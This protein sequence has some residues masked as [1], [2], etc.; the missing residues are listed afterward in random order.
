M[1]RR[2][3]LRR[4][5]LT[6]LLLGLVAFVIPPGSGPSAAPDAW[7]YAD[8][9]P[10]VNPQ[11]WLCGGGDPGA[12]VIK[13]EHGNWHCTW[14]S[15]S[16]P[17]WGLSFVGF[18]RQFILDY[19]L[20]RLG[21][22]GDRVEIWDF[23]PNAV[24][25][26]DDETTATAFT[27]CPEYPPDSRPAGALCSGCMAL[28]ASLNVMNIG[29][30]ATLGHAG[31]V[32]NSSGWHG[33]FH[34]AAG[35]AGAPC[36]E[37]AATPTAT[38]D[39]IFWMGHLKVDDLARTWQRA[40]AADIVVV[41]DRSGSMNDDCDA[42]ADCSGP[43]PPSD[44]GC[45]LNAAKT[46]ALL[47]A[48]LLDDAGVDGDQ[49][50]IG[51]VSFAGTASQ[52]VGLTAATG[53]VTDN[54][55]DETPFEAAVAALQACGSTSI[56][57]GIQKAI[58][59]LQDT[60]TNPHQAIIVLTDG[61][62]NTGPDIAAVAGALGL[63]QLC[64]IGIDSGGYESALRTVAE[65]HGGVFIAQESVDSSSLT[66]EK[67]FVSCFAQIF[68]EAINEDPHFTFPAG[69][70]ATGPVPLEVLAESS[71]LM[72]A[73]GFRPPAGQ[74]PGEACRLRWLITSPAGDLVRPA[75]AGVETGQGPQWAFQRVPL[76]YRGEHAGRWTARLIRPHRIFLHG[77]P[78]DAYAD[79]DSGIA[80][81]REEI[82]RVIPDGA[83]AVL[84]YED[85][86]LTGRSS[87]AAALQLEVAAGLV[88]SVVQAGNAAEFHDLLLQDWDL[89]V[90]ARQID[91]T[92][93][94]YDT[95]LASA[96]CRLRK[97][98]VTDLFAP[99]GAA[100]QLY[101]CLGVGVEPGS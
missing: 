63:I 72:F 81:V 3:R 93:Q 75:Q 101:A 59:M 22:G 96:L 69:A 39:P 97:G 86:N 77:F 78:T 5:A 90:F 11:T 4:Q 88:D 21:L 51:L 94:V 36:N 53:V 16:T 13:Q 12:Q 52:D 38:R 83:K 76:P 24:I 10:A 28:P 58:D 46:A 31:A 8:T 73:S 2:S 25:P 61:R 27:H 15:A 18:H 54:G 95:R 99:A 42:T 87:Y 7:T 60:G 55:M 17:E 67:F 74:A 50:R 35:A 66:L 41:I 49:H 47:L 82:H 33:N 92:P 30:F 6:G 48:D 70:V 64:A 85:G 37:I 65:S 91:P 34:L 79:A 56:G 26:G 20:W 44:T 23:G 98:L 1:T 89:I 45:R 9:Q 19:D 68:D 84:Y 71:K 29:S 100:N 14:P 62:Q 32:L 40:K 43:N 57:D 80:L